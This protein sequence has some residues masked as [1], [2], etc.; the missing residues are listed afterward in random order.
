MRESEQSII[1]C[2]VKRPWTLEKLRRSRKGEKRFAAI[3]KKEGRL[4]PSEPN[5]RNWV[6]FRSSQE[7]KADQKKRKGKNSSICQKLASVTAGCAA[8]HKRKEKKKSL[9][10]GEKNPPTERPCIN[11]KRSW[12][13]ASR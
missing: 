3:P 1:L 9:G 5:K 10:T 13:Y 4:F 2:V 11:V 8:F 7:K 12:H 6:R